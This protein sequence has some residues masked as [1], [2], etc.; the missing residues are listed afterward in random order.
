MTPLLRCEKLVIGHGK[1]PLLPPLDL[2]IHRGDLVVVVGGNG[3]GKTT[4]VK[5]ILGLMS[6]VGGRVTLATPKPRLAY[7][8]QATELDELLPIRVREM[9]GWGRLF[10]FGFLWPIQRRVDRQRRDRALVDAG[11]AELSKRR[12]RDLSGG[13]R[14]RVLIA[15]VLAS[16]ADLAVLDEPT[17]ALDVGGERSVYEHLASLARERNIAIA[18]VTHALSAA[19]RHATKLVFFDRSGHDGAGSVHIGDPAT[20]F[21][22]ATFRSQFGEVHP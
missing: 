16:D 17:A 1:K 21:A 3:A 11:C 10:G 14:Q 19:A 15:R 8:P 13:Q 22:T 4:W 18:V 2:E 12:V 20:V 9:V 5:T 6:P 7:I